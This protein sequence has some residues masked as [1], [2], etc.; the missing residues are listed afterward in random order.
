MKQITFLFLALVLATSF[1]AQTASKKIE[2]LKIEWPEDVKW[3]TVASHDDK[4]TALKEMIPD[5]EKPDAWTIFATQMAFKD[6]KIVSTNKV[7]Q[8]Y[9]ESSRQESPRA[10]LTILEQNDSA[11]NKFVVFKIETESFPE[12]PKPESQLYY[13]VQGESTLFVNFVAVKEKELSS[14][15]VNKWTRIFKKS[16][17]AFVDPPASKHA[18]SGAK[19]SAQADRGAK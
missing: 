10:N 7:V 3:K 11:A 17:L 16:E 8:I 13:A 15:F 2:T 14:D 9:K 6:K 5:T 18:A 1:S 12:D 4:T 19:K